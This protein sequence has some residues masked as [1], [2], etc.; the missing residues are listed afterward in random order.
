VSNAKRCADE[1]RRAG[2]DR[3]GQAR[4][5]CDVHVQQRLRP[6]IRKSTHVRAERR[7]FIRCMERLGADVRACDAHHTRGSNGWKRSGPVRHEQPRLNR[8]VCMRRYVFSFLQHHA[9]VCADGSL[10]SRDLVWRSTNVQQS[11]VPCAGAANERWG[12]CVLFKSRCGLDSNLYV[13]CAIHAVLRSSAHV[14]SDGSERCW[15]VERCRTHLH[16]CSVLDTQRADERSG[17]IFELVER[18]LHRDVQL[19][20]GLRFVERSNADVR[21]RLCGCRGGNVERKR[22]DVCICNVCERARKARE[23][24]S[25]C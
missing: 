11:P 22:A 6:L 9:D 14:Q 16:T 19:R 2:N 15:Y 23:R 18:R 20:Y 8:N 5:R 7:E 1:R 17:I 3:Y 4:L 21:A 10:S 12:D 24:D 13:R 25:N